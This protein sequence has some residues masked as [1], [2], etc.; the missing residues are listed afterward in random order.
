MKIDYVQLG[1]P[2]SLTNSDAQEG[3]RKENRA[4][5][6][7]GL[8]NWNVES[9]GPAT[10]EE[11]ELVRRH[12]YGWAGTVERYQDGSKNIFVKY[13]RSPLLS[14]GGRVIGVVRVRP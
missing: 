9:V 1:D 2:T 14:E 7:Y 4:K 11:F 5:L 12:S 3:I 8:Q 6:T 13:T 10:T